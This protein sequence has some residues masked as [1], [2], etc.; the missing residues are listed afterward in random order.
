MADITISGLGDITPA[1]GLLIPASNSSTNTTGKV[2]LAQ[3]C[4]VMTSAQITTALGYTPQPAL[5]YT[6][7]QQGGGAGQTTNKLYIGWSASNLLLQVD[8]TN[9][10][11]TWP[12]GISGNA[13][14]SSNGAKAWVNF[15]GTVVTVVGSESRC[16]IRSSYNIDRVVRNAN[17]DY[18]VYFATAFANADYCAQVTSGTNS[19]LGSNAPGAPAHCIGTQAAGNIRVF[20]YNPNTGAATA[21]LNNKAIVNVT[22]FN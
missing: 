2:T 22:I 15:N 10:G 3:V 8:A 1:T 7:V 5:G 17:G 13:A 11:N 16:Q 21:G 4:G 14:S 6:P 19:V 9:F 20:T 18:S 12:V